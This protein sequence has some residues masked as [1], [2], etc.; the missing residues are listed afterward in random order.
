MHHPIFLKKCLK[1]GG[2]FSTDDSNRYDP[3][4]DD[5]NRYELIENRKI[6]M[7]KII[8]KIDVE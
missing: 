1:K 3:L 2:L 7:T 8:T 6:T 4:A 5:S